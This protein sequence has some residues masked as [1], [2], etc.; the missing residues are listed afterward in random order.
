MLGALDMLTHWPGFST[1]IEPDVT[2]VPPDVGLPSALKYSD[3]SAGTFM[4]PFPTL[5]TVALAA[6]QLQLQPEVKTN[7]LGALTSGVRVG[8]DGVSVGMPQLQDVGEASCCN[9]G[10][11]AL[12]AARA[13]VLIA[14]SSKPK[15]RKRK[16]L[17]Y[18][19][20][21]S[22]LI[23]V[24]LLCIFSP[25]SKGAAPS[26]GQSAGPRLPPSASQAIV[27]D[28]KMVCKYWGTDKSAGEVSHVG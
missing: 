25:H 10:S 27:P 17:A 2:S 26:N 28:I 16:P 24:L 12:P 20:R 22:V 6:V 7:E 15:I 5:Q 1:P 21:V 19:T 8:P 23:H 11:S 18:S 9:P 4:G 14:E 13:G 3:H